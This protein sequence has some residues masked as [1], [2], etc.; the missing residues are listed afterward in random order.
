MERSREKGGK[1][2]PLT[3]H[4]QTARKTPKIPAKCPARN[5]FSLKFDFLNKTRY[6][7]ITTPPQKTELPILP[8]SG[9]M[10]RESQFIFGGEG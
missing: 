6:T 2:V 8:T 5:E 7:I 9:G 4:A 3:T 1:A 10:P